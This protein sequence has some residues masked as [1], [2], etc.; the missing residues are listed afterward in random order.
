MFIF[1]SINQSSDIYIY[2]CV[3]LSISIYMYPS[4]WHL[5]IYPSIY[6]SVYLYIY[7]YICLGLGLDLDLDLGLEWVGVGIGICVWVW[8]WIWIG[9]YLGEGR[10]AAEEK[11]MVPSKK[12]FR[13]GM[14]LRLCTLFF[15]FQAFRNATTSVGTHD[16][17]LDD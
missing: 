9:I 5:S 1:L 4:V 14:V 13:W 15:T 3:Y 12:R 2:M 7:L 8:I 11:R 6:L 16:V 10:Y 17:H